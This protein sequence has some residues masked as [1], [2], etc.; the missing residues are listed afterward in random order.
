MPEIMIRKA[1]PED[2]VA[3]TDCHIYCWQTAYKGI[4]PGEFLENMTTEKEQRV[5]Q[6]KRALADPGNCEYYCVMNAENMIGFLII[7]KSRNEDNSYI[8]EI[9]A[10]YLIEEFCGKGFGKDLLDFE[11]RELSRVEPKEIFLWVFEDNNRA[12]RFYEKNR[13]SYDGTKREANYGKPLIQ[14]RYV[15]NA[16]E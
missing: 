15:L 16:S 1:L 3:F 13:F 8:G 12:R 4:V 5:E 6:Y 9:W 2:A 10:I 14:L 7:N 11:I